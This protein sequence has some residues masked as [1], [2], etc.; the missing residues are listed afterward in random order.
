[1]DK[2][3]QAYGIAQNAD[4][5]TPKDSVVLYSISYLPTRENKDLAMAYLQSH[6]EC[7]TLDNTPCG[8]ELIALGLETGSGCPDT[9]ILKVWAL[10]SARFIAAAS[11]NVTAFVKNADPRSTFVS[12]ELPHILQNDKIQL[13]NGQD[14]HLFA[15]QFNLS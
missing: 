13:I 8:K 9:E 11:G 3:T 10:A 12:V 7:R 14:K 4:V 1:M 2:L 5:S 15:K 6:P